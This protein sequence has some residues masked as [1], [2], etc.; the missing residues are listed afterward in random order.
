MHLHN[1]II[2]RF[3]PLF[4]I[5]SLSMIYQFHSCI[6]AWVSI[7]GLD[8]MRYLQLVEFYIIKST[9]Y[10]RKRIK[11][12]NYLLREFLI[13]FLIIFLLTNRSNALN[14]FYYKLID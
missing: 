11:I 12:F 6:N 13:I 9:L 14:F 8:Q 10:V 7:V 2:Y 1:G 3:M 5:F 4:A